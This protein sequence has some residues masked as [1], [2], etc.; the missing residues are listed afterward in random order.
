MVVA[1]GLV[2]SCSN[3][4]D[5]IPTGEATREVER[6][7]CG[8]YFDGCGFLATD[9][10]TLN[11]NL[12]NSTGE[13]KF[14]GFSERTR[15]K[16]EGIERRQDWCLTDDYSYDC[17]CMISVDGTGKYF[18]FRGSD[19][20]GPSPA[21]C[22]SVQKAEHGLKSRVSWRAETVYVHQGRLPC[23]DFAMSNSAPASHFSTCA[24]FSW[25][26]SAAQITIKLW[27]GLPFSALDHVAR[28]ARFRRFAASFASAGSGGVPPGIPWHGR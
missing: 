27:G 4:D 28:S 19:G 3:V 23:S 5:A 17:A 12:L 1:L 6:W 26:G 24:G 15:F 13:V 14:S 11:A 10:V 21:I 9:C 18:D 22:S 20:R 7:R 8:D 16:I 2:V 25:C